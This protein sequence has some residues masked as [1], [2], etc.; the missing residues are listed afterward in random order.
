MEEVELLRAGLDSQGDEFTEE[1]LKKLV[2]DFTEELPITL[3]FGEE[4]PRVGRIKSLKFEKGALVAICELGSEGMEHKH[5]GTE[6]AARWVVI[7]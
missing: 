4:A 3:G 5:N 1:L 6:L 7:G 2:N